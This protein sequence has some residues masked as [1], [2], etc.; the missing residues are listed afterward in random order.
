[1]PQHSRRAELYLAL[2]V[3]HLERGRLGCT[4]DFGRLA[5]Q[6]TDSVITSVEELLSGK[7]AKELRTLLIALKAELI[8]QEL[9]LDI[10]LVSGQCQ[11]Q[12]IVSNMHQYS[13]FADSRHGRNTL[14]LD[15][16]VH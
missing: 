5:G 9:N 10:G 14:A 11:S 3:D 6:E 13:R 16:H 12:I 4:E 8:G 7:V 15:K 1:M 2:D